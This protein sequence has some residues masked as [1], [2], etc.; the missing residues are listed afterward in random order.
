[1]P[2]ALIITQSTLH[3]ATPTIFAMTTINVSLYSPLTD[4]KG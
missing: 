1:M 2:T 4:A 3:G